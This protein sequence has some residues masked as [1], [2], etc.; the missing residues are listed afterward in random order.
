MEHDFSEEDSN[1]VFYSISEETRTFEDMRKRYAEN[2]LISE[3]TFD[4]LFNFYK[5]LKL[6]DESFSDYLNREYYKEIEKEH[7]IFKD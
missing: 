1:E 6:E 7:F 3:L 5:P 2:Y 4:T